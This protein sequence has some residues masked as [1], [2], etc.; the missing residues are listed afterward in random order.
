VTNE[1]HAKITIEELADYCQHQ[2][3]LANS[4]PIDDLSYTG[5]CESMVLKIALAALQ[6]KPKTMRQSQNESRTWIECGNDYH[7]GTRFYPN[8]LA[9]VFNDYGN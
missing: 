3:A 9:K 2:I 8:P 5:I 1:N 6:A 7:R 4:V